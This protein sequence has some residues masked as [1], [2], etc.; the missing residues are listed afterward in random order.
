MI[1]FIKNSMIVKILLGLIVIY[2]VLVTFAEPPGYCRS[3]GRYILDEEF[4]RTSEA[5]LEWSDNKNR[6]KWIAEPDLYANYIR[7]DRRLQENRKRIGFVH[8]VRGE[9][10]SI[11]RRLFGYQEIQ[12]ILNVNS[13]DEWMRF[14]YDSC[15]KLIPSDLGFLGSSIGDDV[16]TRN[17]QQLNTSK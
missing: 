12:V 11:F 13:G 7:S 2:L 1:S 4:I 14:F 17:Y 8:V 15:G 16:T 10:H 6:P 9:T 5:L 3:Q